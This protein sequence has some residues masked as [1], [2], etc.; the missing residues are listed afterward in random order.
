MALNKHKQATSA[1]SQP[2]LITDACLIIEQ[3]Q[4]SAYRAVN[5]TLIKNQ[6]EFMVFR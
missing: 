2:A 6:K 3:A 1:P 5:E 4:T